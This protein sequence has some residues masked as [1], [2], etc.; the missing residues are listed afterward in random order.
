MCLVA[1]GTKQKEGSDYN[2]TFIPVIK[3]NSIMIVLTVAVSE[4]WKLRQLN[5]SNTFLHGHLKERIIVSQPYDFEDK[6]KPTLSTTK[7]TIRSK[8]VT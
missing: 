3:A 6:I 8:T 2:H 1:N 4:G 7:V 5:I